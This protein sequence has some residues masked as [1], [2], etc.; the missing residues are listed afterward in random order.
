[1]KYCPRTIALKAGEVV[2][3]GPSCELTPELLNGIYGAESSDLFL[4][5][6]DHAGISVPDTQATSS[7]A[8]VMPLFPAYPDPRETMPQLAAAG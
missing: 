1:M 3:D 7:R 2:Y 4:P 8:G 5:S 6:L